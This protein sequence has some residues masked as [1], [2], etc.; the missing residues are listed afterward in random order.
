M[1]APENLTEAQ[2]HVIRRSDQLIRSMKLQRS[3]TETTLMA[4][5]HFRGSLSKVFPW[6][7]R[8]SK[9]DNDERMTRL[10]QAGNDEMTP[11]QLFVRAYDHAKRVADNYRGQANRVDKKVRKIR[12]AN[13]RY[14]PGLVTFE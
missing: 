12:K 10:T 7:T 1:R 4:R 5:Q 2:S 13:S 9:Q 11:E 6:K 3:W 8:P 14:D